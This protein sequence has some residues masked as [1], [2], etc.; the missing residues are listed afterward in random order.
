M[1]I[2]FFGSYNKNY[3]RNLIL[4]ESLR[5]NNIEI[6]DFYLKSERNIFRKIIELFKIYNNNYDI[7][8]ITDNFR[9]F[10]FYD[11]LLAK[12]L[13]IINRKK[14]V[15]DK[16]ISLYVSGVIEYKHYK[17][18]SWKSLMIHLI[19]IFSLKLANLVITDTMSRRKLFIKFFNGNPKKI[20]RVFLGSYDKI[21]YPRP[22]N[23]NKNKFIITYYGSFAPWM[24]IENIIKAANYLKD[25]EDIYF[26]LIGDGPTFNK[27]NKMIM[28]LKL[29]NVKL[30]GRVPFKILPDYINKGN[31]MLAGHFGQTIKA[32]IT[33]GNKVFDGLALK[34][35]IIVTNT[36]AIKE[37]LTDRVNC[38]ISKIDDPISLKEKIVELYENKSLRDKIAING[39]KLFKE[40]CS[41]Q[42]I[43]KNFKKYLFSLYE[44]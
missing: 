35:P 33:I 32:Q 42:I 5:Q 31:I 16:I 8:F 41:M 37:L 20:K 18:D 44:K 10:T 26:E 27:I 21:F 13:S 40:K 43:G 30:Y 24:G 28:D 1:K 3:A 38:L 34:M 9:K 19:E 4:R 2:A 17:K 7:L 11:I 23:N 22:K 39:Y 25:Y 12:F 29:N 36:I 6:I 14:L 15:I